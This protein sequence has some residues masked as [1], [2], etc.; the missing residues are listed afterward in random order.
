MILTGPFHLTIFSDS[1]TRIQ[2]QLGISVYF[3]DSSDTSLSFAYHQV[4]TESIKPN[5]NMKY[6]FLIVAFGPVKVIS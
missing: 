5:H 6:F 4:L 3:S 2:F 1:D